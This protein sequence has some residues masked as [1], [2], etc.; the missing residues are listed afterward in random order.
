MMGTVR[1]RERSAQEFEQLL[2]QAGLALERVW[3]VR[4]LVSVVDARPSRA[5]LNRGRS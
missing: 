1:G 4:G 2:E 3:P 5:P